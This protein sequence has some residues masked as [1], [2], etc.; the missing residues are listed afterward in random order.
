MA[1]NGQMISLAWL[2]DDDYDLVNSS[3]GS[4]LRPSIKKVR[5]AKTKK[6]RYTK[7]CLGPA[8]VWN[9]CSINRVAIPCTMVSKHKVA[10]V[11]CKV[12]KACKLFEII[13]QSE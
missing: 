11:E 3:N 9:S 6:E 1:N 4:R 5:H 7:T 13:E 8:A 10:S 2:I 12:A